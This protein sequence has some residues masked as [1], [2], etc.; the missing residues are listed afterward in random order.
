MKGKPKERIRKLE[1]ISK[2]NR[3]SQSPDERWLGNVNR[4]R[5]KISVEPIIKEECQYE[6]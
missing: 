6:N 3:L 1:E 4:K 2:L 5:K